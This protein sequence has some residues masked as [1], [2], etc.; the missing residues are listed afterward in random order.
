MYSMDSLSNVGSKVSLK[1]RMRIRKWAS[2]KARN[3]GTGPEL[4]KEDS[5]LFTLEPKGSLDTKGSAAKTI[6]YLHSRAA[7]NPH[8]PA[9]PSPF[10]SNSQRNYSWLNPLLRQF[11]VAHHF[12]GSQPAYRFAVRYRFG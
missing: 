10:T 9:W 8:V 4:Q 11:W 3:K 7:V 5:G 1:L 6:L 2:Q 12:T